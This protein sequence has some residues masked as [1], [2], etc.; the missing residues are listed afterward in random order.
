MT[1]LL[2]DKRRKYYSPAD[3]ADYLG[4]S[5][6]YVYRLIEQRELEASRFGRA[7]RIARDEVLRYEERARD[8]VS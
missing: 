8:T 7:V 1:D 6:S 3:V 2:T 4:I 5:R